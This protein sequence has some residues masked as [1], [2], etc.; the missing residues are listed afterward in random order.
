MPLLVLALPRLTRM[1]FRVC[2]IALPS[3]H[4]KREPGLLK[5]Q[6]SRLAMEEEFVRR[7]DG[8]TT[9][10]EGEQEKDEDGIEPPD[11]SGRPRDLTGPSAPLECGR[12]EKTRISEVPMGDEEF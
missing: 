10:E 8:T 4:R 9:S 3:I 6:A 7:E 5:G 1:C 11:G 12:G 2:P